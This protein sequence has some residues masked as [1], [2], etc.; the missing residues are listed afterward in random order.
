[1]AA[2]GV[3]FAPSFLPRTEQAVAQAAPPS[4]IDANSFKRL[5]QGMTRAQAEAIL[6]EPGRPMGDAKCSV[7]LTLWKWQG[8]GNSV[9]LDIEDEVVVGGELQGPAP[10]GADAGREG[11]VLTHFGLV[12][13]LYRPLPK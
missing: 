4:G 7:A 3:Y 11:T 6:G 1:M 9:V 8:M 13:W 5:K 12:R 10:T 2:A